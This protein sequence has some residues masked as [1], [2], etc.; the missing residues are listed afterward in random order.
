MPNKRTRSYKRRVGENKIALENGRITLQSRSQRGRPQ[1]RAV[2]LRQ[3]NME[4]LSGLER[5]NSFVKDADKNEP[6]VSCCHNNRIER[7]QSVPE[8][9]SPLPVPLEPTVEKQSEE[10]SSNQFLN[11]VRVST[12]VSTASTDIVSNTSSSSRQVSNQPSE[13][14][15]FP[16]LLQPKSQPDT[17]ELP[18]QSP[19]TPLRRN[20]ATSE[21]SVSVGRTPRGVSQQLLAQPP[22]TPIVNRQKDISPLCQESPGDTRLVMRDVELDP[23]FLDERSASHDSQQ[24]GP[25]VAEWPRDSPLNSE[26]KRDSVV[27]ASQGSVGDGSHVSLEYIREQ[28]I[29]RN[30]KVIGR[31][32]KTPSEDEIEYEGI[33]CSESKEE[34]QIVDLTMHREKP[35]M[36]LM[37]TDS[38]N[39]GTPHEAQRTVVF[40]INRT[41]NLGNKTEKTAK[42]TNP[43]IC[44]DKTQSTTEDTAPSTPKLPEKETGQ[45][46]SKATANKPIV[47]SSKDHDGP[48]RDYLAKCAISKPSSQRKIPEKAPPTRLGANW[49]LNSAAAFFSSALDISKIAPPVSHVW[50]HSPTPVPRDVSSGS[51]GADSPDGSETSYQSSL[52]W[53]FPSHIFSGKRSDPENQNKTDFDSIA[54]L[55]PEHKQ[56]DRVQASTAKS[57]SSEFQFQNLWKSTPSISEKA[58]THLGNLSSDQSPLS[59]VVSPLQ[60]QMGNVGDKLGVDEE[61]PSL[62]KE[63]SATLGQKQ[64]RKIRVKR[65]PTPSCW[66]NSWLVYCIILLMGSMCLILVGLDLA[67]SKTLDTILGRRTG[68][69]QTTPSLDPIPPPPLE[70]DIFVGLDFTLAPQPQPTNLPTTLAPTLRKPSKPSKLWG[71]DYGNLTD[72]KDNV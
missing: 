38:C 4:P 71:R 52:A 56:P 16:D 6:S 42:A 43:K 49:S 7:M 67:G 68:D 46:L 40:N 54:F 58:R 55:R 39:A 26:S 28:R 60:H 70:A 44:L 65:K 47:K 61:N 2:N 1:S 29:R 57:T 15:S 19:L 35:V 63:G 45:T 48:P 3:I 64:L 32:L 24:Q 5:T 11:L 66:M 50:V 41:T 31:M 37:S 72:E 8:E 53:S 21:R 36:C 10:E 23:E 34:A 20:P 27:L 69:T 51:D 18:P 62:D 59:S 33:S 22:S 30:V 25:P 9:T 14:V 13:N 17:T 12:T